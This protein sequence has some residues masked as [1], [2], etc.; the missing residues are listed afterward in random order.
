M[1]KSIK[2]ICAIAVAGLVAAG[3]SA[4]TG[5][6]VT[7]NAPGSV[8][9]GGTVNQGV[10]GATLSNIAYTY[11]DPT[12]TAVSTIVL[13]FADATNGATPTALVTATAADVFT[14]TAIAAGTFISTCTGATPDP[15]MSN[16]AITVP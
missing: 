12:K 10:T 2:F 1:G 6:G 15:G 11:S 5:T 14:C 3:A 13:T 9:V 16:V 7:D 8:F 4:F